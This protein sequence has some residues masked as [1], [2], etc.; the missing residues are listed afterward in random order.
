MGTKG[1]ALATS[2]STTLTTILLI[3]DTKQQD[4]NNGY[5]QHGG[6]KKG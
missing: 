1:I 3:K 2:I 6:I 5:P 4:K